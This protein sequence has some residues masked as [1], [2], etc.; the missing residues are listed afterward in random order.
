MALSTVLIVL[1]V[2]GLAGSFLGSFGHVIVLGLLALTR[3]GRT[4]LPSGGFEGS[5]T[6][7]VPVH[8]EV[9][10]LRRKCLILLDGPFPSDRVQLIVAADGPVEGLSEALAEPLG[11]KVELLQ[12]PRCG[13][14]ALLSE[15]ARHAASEIIVV[16]DRD[17]K[18]RNV[19]LARLVAVF[20]DPLIGGA[21]G[22]VVIDRE[23]D[24]SQR[25]YWKIENVARRWENQWLGNLTAN[26]GALT[27]IRR[28][29]WKAIPEE[30]SDDLFLA[31][32]VFLQD[33][34]FVYVE[35]ARAKIP[36]RSQGVW[37]AVRRQAR[38]VTGSM[39]TL[40]HCRAA[41]NPFRSGAFALVLLFHKVFRRLVP[42]FT[43]LAGLALFVWSVVEGHH[44]LAL[45]IAGAALAG[46]V[47]LP[48]GSRYSHVFRKILWL[49]AV[50]LGMAIGVARFLTNRH[51]KTW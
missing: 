36:P 14:A 18:V 47:L 21:C 13:K 20:S 51:A 1:A 2:I 35:D 30:C 28:K 27:A 3:K 29:Y 45:T 32:T 15:A 31:L 33:A 17:A 25:A 38:I 50:Q 41:L 4:V 12:L 19:D 37:A 23:K 10:D 34:R 49:G 43:V 9:K 40:W 5:V 22:N 24:D 8:Q 39:Y 16:S 6:V 48:L 42:Y 26:S 7:I 11:S 44:G 46:A